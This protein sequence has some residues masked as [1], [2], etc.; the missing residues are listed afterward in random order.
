MTDNKH[1]PGPWKYA[2]AFEENAPDT[3]LIHDGTWGA[4]GIAEVPICRKDDAALIA[5][6]PELLAC[7]DMLFDACE[8]GASASEIVDHLDWDYLRSVYVKARGDEVT[9]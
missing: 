6:A 3:W 9:P 4:P 5:A 1:T 2:R 7:L 8:D